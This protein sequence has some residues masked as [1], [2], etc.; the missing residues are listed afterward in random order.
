MSAGV[1]NLPCKQALFLTA[2]LGLMLQTACLVAVDEKGAK[3]AEKSAKADEK[4]AKADEKSNEKAEPYPVAAYVDGDPVFVAEIDSVLFELQKT[5]QVNNQN[6][7]QA[8]ADVLKLIIRRRAAER[9]LRREGF[10]KD[11]EVDKEIDKL[12]TQAGQQR[13]AFNEYLKKRRIT[14]GTARHEMAWKVGWD[15][16]SE[17]K[18]GEA[19]QKYFEDHRR[20]L[21][22][23]TLRASH[24]LLRPRKAGEN[25][26]QLTAHAE[27]IRQEIE[28]GKIS[29]EEAAKKYSAGPSRDQGGDLGFFPRYGVMNDEFGRAAFALKEGE[30][31]KPVPSGFGVHLIRVTEVKPGSKQ[32]TEAAAQIKTPATLDLFEKLCKDELEK[33][34]VE[35]TGRVPYYKNEKQIVVPQADR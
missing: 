32:W 3:A 26:G 24:I 15:H 5:R 16:Y 27:Q 8:K 23:T 18:L 20:E 14:L 17:A 30:I 29:F 22:G 12:K 33:I 1:R 19:L 2:L 34:K 35:Y 28:S 7:I 31:S 21:D 6:E 11:S 9:V 10:V 4:S 25:A 13:L